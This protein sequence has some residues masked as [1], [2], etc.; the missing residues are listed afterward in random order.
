VKALLLCLLAA[1]TGPAV[2]AQ[3]P[4]SPQQ[5]GGSQSQ[6]VSRQDGVTQQRARLQPQE[7]GARGREQSGVSALSDGVLVLT[8]LP[9]TYGITLA[10][11]QGTGIRVE[12]LPR[13]GRPMSAQTRYFEKPGDEAL[14]LMREADAVVS[15]GKLWHEDPLFPAVRA[16][17]IRVVNIDATEPY[18]RT[19]SGIALIREP[20]GAAP[21]VAGGTPEQADARPSIYFWLSPSNGARIA[22]IVAHDLALLAPQDAERITQNLAAYRRKLFSLKRTYE[23]K[24]AALENVSVFALTPDFTYLTSD[25]GL[26]V[27]GYFV[28]QDIDWTPEDLAGLT[29]YLKERGLRV[30]LHKWEPSEPIRKAIAAAGAQLVVLRTVESGTAS[31]EGELESNLASLFAALS[32]QEKP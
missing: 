20:S 24:L 13:D 17:N 15:I 27:E 14:V 32:R 19:M 1:A 10:L 8:T 31:Y 23:E 28:K 7:Q 6:G 9:A 3:Q 2:L 30:V 25:V 26:F 29:R 5:T 11:A 16:Q 4:G 18:S 22:E 12:N 21:W